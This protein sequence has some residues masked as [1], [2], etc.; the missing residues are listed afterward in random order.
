[1]P[2]SRKYIQLYRNP[3]AVTMSDG[4]EL[5]MGEPAVGL[6]PDHERVFIR[7]THG[8]ITSLSSD[9]AKLSLKEGV[10]IGYNNATDTFFFETPYSN[11]TTMCDFLDETAI[12]LERIIPSVES[13]FKVE[14]QNGQPVVSYDIDTSV[15]NVI[16]SK[17]AE[18]AL[19]PIYSGDSQTYSGHTSISSAEEEY[20][21]HYSIDD[22]SDVIIE[23]N[24]Y[25]YLVGT[26]T[27][28]D[29]TFNGDTN[30][31]MKLYAITEGNVNM[32][33]STAYGE[34]IWLLSP[35]SLRI[36]RVTSQKI[37][38]ALDEDN[39]AELTLND[40]T[41]DCYRTTQKLVE[42]DW[43][44]KLFFS[45]LKSGRKHFIMRDLLSSTYKDFLK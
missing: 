35:S 22:L 25:V 31:Q 19:M 2:N 5:L 23:E 36:R 28:T 37:E 39:M 4:T 7:N 18:N 40:S 34:Y 20:V 13:N 14:I 41:L 29:D 16:I 24:H 9:F 17:R 27:T 15:K 26:A 30:V 11:V 42:C 6:K 1:M 32:D 21:I 45:G 3:S 43:K 8:N 12:S 33:V 44:L 10:G 38:V